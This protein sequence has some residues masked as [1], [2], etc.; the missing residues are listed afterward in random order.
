M[1]QLTFLVEKVSVKVYPAFFLLFLG[2]GVGIFATS[3][4]LARGLWATENRLDWVRNV[5][6]D[7]DAPS[8]TVR[9]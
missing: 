9:W 4:G 1:I 7:E 5:T 3:S 8:D 2:R 6:F